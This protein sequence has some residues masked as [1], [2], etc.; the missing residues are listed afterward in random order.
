MSAAR[1]D[2]ETDSASS[3]EDVDSGIAEELEKRKDVDCMDLSEFFRY[4]KEPESSYAY[5]DGVI[6][7]DA[8]YYLKHRNTLNSNT[9]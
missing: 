1:S 7:A 6:Q 3:E 5:L 2:S 8:T 4:W 9:H